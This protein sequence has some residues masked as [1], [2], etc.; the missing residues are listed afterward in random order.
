MNVSYTNIFIQMKPLLFFFLAL[1][2]TCGILVP[3][4]PGIE[5]LAVKAQTWSPNHWTARE[6][7]ETF[8]FLFA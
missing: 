7:P 1:P 6:F 4:R 8:T 2:P 3:S 5:P